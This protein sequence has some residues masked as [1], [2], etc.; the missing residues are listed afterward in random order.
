MERTGVERPRLAFTTLACPAWSLERVTEAA[1][2][3]GYQGVELRLLDGETIEPGI[4]AAA[5]RR[6]RSSLD[7]AGLPVVALDTSVRLAAADPQAAAAE[8]KAMLELAAEWDAPLVRVFGGGPPDDGMARLLASTA[9]DAERLG[10]GIAV[11]THDHFS[12]AATVADLLARVDSPAV[13]ALWD[14]LHTYRVGEAPDVAM[15]LLGDRL[16]HVHVKDGRRRPDAEAWDLVLLGEGDVPIAPTLRALAGHG[17]R[18]WLSVEWE[19]KWHP[20]IAEPEVALPQ[21]A[22]ELSRLLAGALEARPPEP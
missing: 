15:A 14:V 16:I 2:A 13:G 7:A 21:H 18:G 1:L 5:R 22:A 12:S 9:A 4:D 11:E 19:K 10:V 17:Y 6:V 3:Y 8:L 20:E